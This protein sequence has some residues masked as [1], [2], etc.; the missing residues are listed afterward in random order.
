MNTHQKYFFILGAAK[1]GTSSLYYY[2]DQHPDILMSTPKETLFF[3]KDYKK[4][5]T[6]YRGKYF[7]NYKGEAFLGEARHRN[8]Y[9]P[10]VPE[11]I[12]ESFPDAKLIIILRNPVDRAYSH[13][14]HRKNR[15]VELLNFKDAIKEDE[16]RIKNGILFKNQSD[17][18]KYLKQLATDGAML[19]YRTYLDSGYYV[20]QIERYLKLFNRDQIFITFTEDLKKDVRKTYF[21]LLAFLDKDLR[22]IDIDFSEQNT[23]T[24][25][26]NI[27]FSNIASKYPAVKSFIPKWAKQ[28]SYIITDKISTNESELDDEIRLWLIS[29]YKE[30]NKKLER[31]TGRDLSH[32]DIT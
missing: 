16:M 4:D 31:L 3:E 27:Q 5:L 21:D 12:A 26:L 18:E 8:L 29:H 25:L 6:Y 15:G 30:H 11:R 19:E 23:R 20:E 32:W 17:I 9:L 13:Y 14:L 7:P 1:C 22:L 24:N 28:I 10:F 2:L